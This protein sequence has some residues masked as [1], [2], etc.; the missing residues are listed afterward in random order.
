VQREVFY[1]H[2]RGYNH[3]SDP[4]ANLP[5]DKLTEVNDALEAFVA[6]MKIHGIW[7]NIVIGTGSD[8]SRTLTRNSG[9]RTDHGCVGYCFMMREAS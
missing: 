6:E 9:D 1:I 3:R 8:F 4:Q 7:D 2:H 5:E